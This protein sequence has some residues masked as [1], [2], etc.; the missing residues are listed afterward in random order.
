MPPAPPAPPAPPPVVPPPPAVPPADP[1]AAPPAPPAFPPLPP[2]VAVPSFFEL[3][4]TTHNIAPAN[5]IRAAVFVMRAFTIERSARIL[6]RPRLR[7]S[8]ATHM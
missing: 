1:P 7:V 3:Q 2:E 4:A 6:E 5:R 8:E